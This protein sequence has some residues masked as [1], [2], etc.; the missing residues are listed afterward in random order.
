MGQTLLG[1]AGYHEQTERQVPTI[2]ES[3]LCSGGQTLNQLMRMSKSV[4]DSVPS[5]VKES[6]GAQ[7]G[8]LPGHQPALQPQGGSQAEVPQPLAGRYPVKGKGG[9]QGGGAEAG[10]RQ[11]AR[12]ILGKGNCRCPGFGLQ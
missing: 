7:G 3:T 6:R 1:S 2:T 10:S 12:C 4:A 11:T 5:V 9:G 8:H